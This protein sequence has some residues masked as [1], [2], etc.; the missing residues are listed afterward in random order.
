MLFC[1]FLLGFLV[2]VVQFGL[3]LFAC[4]FFW[5]DFEGVLG[6]GFLWRGGSDL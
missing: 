3:R 4:G 1:W 6:L 5:G 2:V